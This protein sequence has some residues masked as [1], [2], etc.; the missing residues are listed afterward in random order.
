MH[1][2]GSTPGRSSSFLANWTFSKKLTLAG[3]L[4]FVPFLTISSFFYNQL[5]KEISFS[6][7]EVV[8]IQNA[9]GIW[10]NL[11]TLSE[12]KAGLT[13][14]RDPKATLDLLKSLQ[15]KFGPTLET[16]AAFKKYQAALTAAGWPSANARRQSELKVAIAES[17]E[18]IRD[19]SDLSN[20]T[21]DPDL[22]TYYLMD[23]SMMKLPQQIERI[24]E[25]YDL[26]LW[27]QQRQHQT[28]Q[29]RGDLFALVSV[30]ES[31]KQEIM[32]SIERAIRGNADGSVVQKV[33]PKLDAY[34]EASSTFHSKLTRFGFEIQEGGTSSISQDDA[35]AA[36]T[37]LLQTTSA[38]WDTNSQTLQA[39]L[40][41]RVDGLQGKGSMIFLIL[42]IVTCLTTLLG[43]LL[44][45][46]MLLGLASLKRTIDQVAQGE[47]TSKIELAS[48]KTEMGAIARSIERLRAS[49]IKQLE[50]A[51]SSEASEA[52]NRQRQEMV[53]GIAAQ[54][55]E[56]VETILGE[57]NTAC[58]SL[59]E[60][61][62]H[63]NGNAEASQERLQ[64]TAVRLNS[65]TDHVVRVSAS[66]QEL[67]ASTNE[68][69]EQ[70]SS[71]SSVADR[72]RDASSLVQS[73]L[74]DLQS[75]IQ[76]ISD[77]GGLI[78]G[79]ASQTNLLA[80]NATIEAARAGEAGRGF[81]VVA[82]EVK[83]LS[84]QTASATNEIASQ[85]IQVS[86]AAESVT[87][88]VLEV[89]NLISE[90]TGT[91]MTI[92]SATEQQSVMTSEISQT[93]EVA[94][95]DSRIVAQ[96]LNG[97]TEQTRSVRD[98]A[99]DLAE[100]SRSLSS[101]ANNVGSRIGKLISDLK[102]A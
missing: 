25:V 7:K 98:R 64:E 85:L 19:V 12:T 79:I 56:Q 26:F 41:K 11:V 95:S 22:D 5:K 77:I 57:L 2:S 23:V 89:T 63:V 34:V 51:H 91:S 35:T 81:A 50:A 61:V 49:V 60:T 45:R 6:A 13:P 40:E 43:I 15:D 67:A 16:D 1:K 27:L 94:A 74:D 59:L 42:G 102:A 99:K 96:A 18:F 88:T 4:S 10:S 29:K 72:A 100:L 73:G 20:L 8:G 17:G 53:G 58:R 55:S 30:M 65:T 70:T 21:L 82:S 62:E 71:A 36:L 37:T 28:D 86:A 14:Q 46:N 32:K 76:K 92:A 83:L 87:R 68:I 48:R 52:L 93:I 24:S 54:I 38:F 31:A 44:S 47:T 3:V 69:A 101:T 33:K 75:S 66:I 90:I 97:V 84:G 39:L 80:L 9:V 78:S